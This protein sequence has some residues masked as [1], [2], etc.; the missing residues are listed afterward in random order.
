MSL[1]L[2]A[3][4]NI[5]H[6]AENKKAGRF[7]GIPFPYP[8]F[9]QFIPSI[10]KE[11]V[12]GVT[13][14]SGAGKS[15][16]SRHTF[17]THPYEFSLQNNYPV[18]IDYYCLE[19]S[20]ERT[21][22]YILCNYLYMKCG[23]RVSVYD[24]DSKYRELAPNI[25][26]HIIDGEKYLADFCNK[27]RIKDTFTRASDIR[28]DILT[29]ANKTGTLLVNDKKDIVGYEPKAN[30]HW[31]AL[32]DNLN[33]I[34]KEPEHR[35]QKQS[36]DHFVQSD[37]RLLYSKI[38]KMTPVIV[39]QQA[40]EAEKQQFTNTGGLI[41]DKNKPSLA[42]L[43]GTKEVTRSYHMVMS[44]FDPSRFKVLSYK[45]YDIG[46]LKNNFRELEILK[47]N[48]GG[49][50]GTIVAPLYFDGAAEIFRELPNSDKQKDELDRFYK[51]HEQEKLKQQNRHLLF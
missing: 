45:G 12:I 3:F 32:F 5:K 15:K 49:G 23:E 35:D 34:E 31:I 22:K 19:D 13:S 26:K 24:L 37:C 42:N 20:A 4:N 28:R 41:L 10:D 36:M 40:L 29:R 48:D 9:S 38:L 1:Y 50:D 46:K 39:H 44:L 21:F 7:D 18:E 11:Q 51:W 27:V 16:F 8:R 47:S 6:K 2:R 14:Y 30:V 17:I 25:M 33:N 43:G